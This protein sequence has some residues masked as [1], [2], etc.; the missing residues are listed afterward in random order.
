MQYIE[1]QCNA[2]QYN[3]K[4]DSY[5]DTMASPWEGLCPPVKGFMQLWLC[6]ICVMLVLHTFLHC[7]AYYIMSMVYCTLH[8]TMCVECTVLYC[9]ILP[10]ALYNVFSVHCTILYCTLYELFSEHC[11]TLYC[12][13]YSLPTQG[14]VMRIV[15]RHKRPIS[16]TYY[17]ETEHSHTLTVWHSFTQILLHSYS[18]LL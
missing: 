4:C 13:L 14:A 15:R 9:T 11:T 16:L 17:Q 12:A 18:L 6:N 3:V 7:T 10:S 8:C 1:D 2:M 5:L